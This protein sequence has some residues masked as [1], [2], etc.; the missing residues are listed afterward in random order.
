MKGRDPG[1]E[2]A[3]AHKLPVWGEVLVGVLTVLT[4]LFFSALALDS[5]GQ[6]LELFETAVR[7]GPICAATI[8]WLGV[9]P[10]MRNNREQ[11]LL[12]E[13]H[14]NLRWA[15]ELC[16][17]ENSQQ[18]ALGIAILDS[19]DDLPFHGEGENTLIDAVIVAVALQYDQTEEGSES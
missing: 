17:R 16:A 4:L 9:S 12:K 11:D 2:N 6:G 13:W 7:L 5:A 19:L 3:P 18:V 15:T 8:A 10:T 14:S 1:A